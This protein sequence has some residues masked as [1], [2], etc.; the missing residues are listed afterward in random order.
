[1]SEE[2]DI[3]EW[4]TPIE[5]WSVWLHNDFIL[6]LAEAFKDE[7]M[8]KLEEVLLQYRAVKDVQASVETV[9]YKGKDRYATGWTDARGVFGK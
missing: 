9:V 1:M 3:P 5:G 6:W 8:G 2:Q 7:P 4:Y